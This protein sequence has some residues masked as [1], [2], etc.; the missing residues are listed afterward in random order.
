MLVPLETLIS[1]NSVQRALDQEPRDKVLPITARLEKMLL[2]HLSSE[3]IVHILGNDLIWDMR[4]QYKVVHELPVSHRPT[5]CHLSPSGS[6][7]GKSLFGALP[8]ICVNTWSIS[9]HIPFLASNI[10]LFILILGELLKGWGHFD[11]TASPLTLHPL[12][13]PQIFNDLPLCR[14]G[15]CNKQDKV[16]PSQC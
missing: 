15:Y 8:L 3:L 4:L 14:C 2:L 11:S 16:L 9:W 12:I 5:S 10:C 1:A 6:S 13:I 7:Q